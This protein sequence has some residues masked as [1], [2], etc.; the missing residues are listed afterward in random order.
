MSKKEFRKVTM[1]YLEK[2]TQYQFSQIKLFIDSALVNSVSKNF[3]TPDEKIK[4]LYTSLNDVRDFILNQTVENSVRINLIRAFDEL[5]AVEKEEQLGNESA[6][7]QESTQEKIEE[8]Q[9]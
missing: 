2:Q 4:Y 8:S 7:F 1:P 9:E 3:E 5:E 6:S